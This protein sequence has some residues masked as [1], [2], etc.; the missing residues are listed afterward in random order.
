MLQMLSF[1]I[2]PKFFIC[3]GQFW[4][5]KLLIDTN[6]KITNLKTMVF[7]SFEE[8]TSALQTFLKYCSVKSPNLQQDAKTNQL[9]QRFV[10]ATIFLPNFPLKCKRKENF[11]SVHKQKMLLYMHTYIY[12]NINTKKDQ[13]L[14]LHKSTYLSGCI[15][16]V[17]KL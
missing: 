5:K 16:I 12:I 7:F 4:M 14:L 9:K 1:C 10:I 2:F 17:Q 11:I 15:H 8:G 13:L 6:V 3:R